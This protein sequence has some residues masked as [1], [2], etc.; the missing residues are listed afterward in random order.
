MDSISNFDDT[1]PL[2]DEV[3][4]EF[5]DKAGDG[6]TAQEWLADH[7]IDPAAIE[8]AALIQYGLVWN[9]KTGR[10]QFVIYEPAVI[11]LL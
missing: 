9:S 3:A 1:L 10:Y 2:P 8:T 4:Q 5:S 7:G 6:L 11:R